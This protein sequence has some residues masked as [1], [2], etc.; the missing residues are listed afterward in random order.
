M[1]KMYKNVTKLG[2]TTETNSCVVNGNSR[3]M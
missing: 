3:E 2:K 1:Y